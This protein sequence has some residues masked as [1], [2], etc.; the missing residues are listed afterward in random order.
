MER[1]KCCGGE[2][3]TREKQRH[4]KKGT[5]GVKTHGWVRV[6]GRGDMGWHAQKDEIT[7]EKRVGGTGS[8]D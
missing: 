2:K 7:Q 5:C 8:L 6:G 1:G 3:K 4:Q